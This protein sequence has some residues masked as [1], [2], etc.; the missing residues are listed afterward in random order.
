MNSLD[1]IK[2]ARSLADLTNSDFISWDD[3][4]NSLWESWKDIYSKITDSSDDYFI[5]SVIIPTTGATQLGDSEW[6]LSLPVEIYKLRF[7]NY[8]DGGRWVNMEKFNT[9]QRNR[10]LS[11]P[12]YRWRGNK[13]WIVASSFGL[14]SQI[15]IDYYP[16]PVK[17]SVPEADYN[18]CTAYPLYQRTGISSLAFT[19]VANSVQTEA[20]DYL[21]YIYNNDIFVESTLLNSKT[22]LYST[23]TAPTNLVYNLG[24]LYWIDGGNMLRASTDFS[25]TLV[26]TTIIN[27]ADVVS[28][29]IVGDKIYYSTA[30]DTN[31][32]TLSGTG[33]TAVYAYAVEDYYEIGSDVYYIIS[34]LLYKNAIATTTSALQLWS[35]GISLYHID[36]ANVLFKDE[37]VFRLSVA[38][39][40]VGSDNFIPVITTGLEIKAIS[41]LDTTEFDYPVN[42]ALEIMAYQSAVDY[43]R[44]QS[45]DTTALL[46]RLQ[47]IWDRFLDVLKRD[48]GQPE[49]RVAEAPRY[50][51]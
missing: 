3:E 40:G 51:Y 45:A 37:D 30:T 21:F 20:T 23:G 48:E 25:S 8:W 6:E 7:V 5:E 43:K 49:R 2:R 39:I 16:S 42:E 46:G 35:D 24:Y 44:K 15:R 11:S 31:Y 4:V 13:L 32:C 1:I 33:V 19:R 29:T 34:G 22:T 50:Y 41:T 47:E 27:T 17:P 14:P 18:Y 9:N 28:F 38:D 36:S 26:P 10:Q 12:R